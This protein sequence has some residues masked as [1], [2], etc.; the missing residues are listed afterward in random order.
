MTKG[1][2]QYHQSENSKTNSLNP[3]E[4]V[5]LWATSSGSVLFAH[6]RY[7][8]LSAVRGKLV[9]LNV[10]GYTSMLFCHYCKG[11]QLEQLWWF[12]GLS[13]GMLI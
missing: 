2:L 4:I 1:L 13:A 11:E 5:L 3:D 8:V 9:Q 12:S 7:F 6:F 10:Y